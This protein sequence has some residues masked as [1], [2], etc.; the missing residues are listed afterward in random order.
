MTKDTFTIENGVPLPDMGP[1]GLG[2]GHRSD[3]QKLSDPDKIRI[4]S[5]SF[6]DFILSTFP[7]TQEDT[8][9]LKGVGFLL[10][11]THVDSK[12]GSPIA[13]CRTVAGF[14]GRDY[15][16]AQNN[17]RDIARYFDRLKTHV[18]PDLTLTSYVAGEECRRIKST[19]FTS[20]VEDAL[21]AELRTPRSQILDPVFLV[22]GRTAN[23][24]NTSRIADLS[25]RAAEKT[26]PLAAS[27]EIREVLQYLNNLPQ[28][29]FT[30]TLVHMSRAYDMASDFPDQPEPDPCHWNSHSG[31]SS[32][33]ASMSPRE[34]AYRTLREIE[35]NPK[36]LYEPGVR[37][38]RITPTGL[39][40]TNIDS[41]IRRELTSKWVEYD[42]KSAQLAINC[43]DWGVPG[44]CAFLESGGDVWRDIASHAFPDLPFDADFKGV[45]KEA[46]YSISYGKSKPK[47][48]A[49]LTCHLGEYLRRSGRESDRMKNSEVSRT[50]TSH[51]I[52]RALLDAREGRVAQIEQEGGTYDDFGNW[53]ALTEDV[54]VKSVL[55]Q[56]AQSIE[57]AMVLPVYR[58]AKTTKDFTVILHQHDGFN[59][60]FHAAT[61]KERWVKRIEQVVAEEAVRRGI[62]TRLEVKTG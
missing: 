59:V 16:C 46:V 41:R 25:R 57:M 60:D 37:T 47:V 17:Y 43:K 31:P 27:D 39:N 19:G 33:S 51:W 52:V 48:K 45:I 32:L 28:N 7:A 35:E 44:V 53:I 12:W 56:R 11:P 21:R 2:R 4:V 15:K 36:P 9:L 20:S 42:L 5:R 18:L 50:F 6:R 24:L 13:C 10:F 3:L 29:G 1:S 62:P 55:A 58:L 34:V 38:A 54:D 40:L 8:S 61:R 30:K 14:E 23:R 26:Y 22:D 49:A